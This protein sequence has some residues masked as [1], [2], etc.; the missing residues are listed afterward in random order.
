MLIYFIIKHIILALIGPFLPAKVVSTTGFSTRT[1]Q[2]EH[3]A[4][5]AMVFKS[6]SVRVSFDKTEQECSLPLS[7]SLCFEL[8]RQVSNLNSS[9]PESDVLPITLRD[10]FQRANIEKFIYLSSTRYLSVEQFC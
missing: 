10:S 2:Q 5:S 8:S 1:W 6:V 3:I 9:D 7:L 4:I